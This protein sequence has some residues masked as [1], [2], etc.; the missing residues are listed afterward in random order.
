[1]A[2]IDLVPD[3]Y[4]YWIWQLRCLKQA[5]VVAI[6]LLVLTAACW[7]YLHTDT[8]NANEKLSQL[9]AQ[10]QVSHNQQQRLEYLS[11][12]QK[13]LERQWQLLLG[14]RGGATVENLFVV[15]DRAL[16]GDQVWFNNWRFRRA[17]QSVSEPQIQPERDRGAY[18][19]ILP[20][21]SEKQASAP[22]AWSIETH[23]NI[24]GGAEDHAALSAFVERL[25]RQPRISDVKVL[26]TSL[27]SSGGDSSAITFDISV[28]VNNAI[29]AAS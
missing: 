28:L 10:K 18:I 17:G 29:G 2:N 15:I 25:L 1:M 14:L 11:S 21:P 7:Y 4:R 23:L 8:R 20:E 12:Q 19:I 13:S 27:Y 6:L 16:L 24:N 26:S 9:Q 5:G 3:D 22:A